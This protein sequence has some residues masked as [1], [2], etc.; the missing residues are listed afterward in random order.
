MKSW[1]TFHQ[2]DIEAKLH[3]ELG[4]VWTSDGGEIDI[5]II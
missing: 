5:F 4:T 3:H 2:K 1:S